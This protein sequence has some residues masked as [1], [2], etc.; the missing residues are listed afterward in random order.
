MEAFYFIRMQIAC[1]FVLLL[2]G[3]QSLRDGKAEDCNKYFDLLFVFAEIEVLFDAL[4]AWS[5]NNST[6]IPWKINLVFHIIFFISLVTCIYLLF[7]YFLSITFGISSKIWKRLLLLLPYIIVIIAV[8][9]NANSLLIVTGKETCYSMGTSV[10]WCFISAVLLWIG[11]FVI[12]VSGFRYIEK[13]KRLSLLICL[14]ASFV[15]ILFQFV[16]PEVL[17]TS[18]S[19]T[20]IVM[21]IYLNLEN[22]AYVKQMRVNKEMVANFSTIIENRDDSTGGHVKRT[23]QYVK[24]LIDEM[25]KMDEYKKILTADFV[26]NMLQAAPMHDIG[27]VSVPDS[28]LRKPGKLTDEE[29]TEMKKHTI[30]GGD[31]IQ[32]TFGIN[33]DR[34]DFAVVAF[35][36]CQFHHEKW[37][38]K[39]YPEGLSGEMI[40]LCARIMAVADVFD[41]VSAKRC[42]RDAMPLEQCFEIIEK[43]VGTD[44]DPVIAGIFLKSRPQVEKVYFQSFPDGEKQ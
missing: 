28:I 22:P 31:I 16:F 38:G 15:T 35:K 6:L 1:L 21:G 9:V 29:F 17:L 5:V 36:V 44:F 8:I 41:A 10:Y 26:N 43:G 27:K 7:L 2:S 32:E 19:I 4:T 14:T 23:T 42:Y 30:R 18:L 34:R 33:P 3:Y 13:H 39:G 24:I 20:V 37:N 40:P 12:L 25:R 11:S